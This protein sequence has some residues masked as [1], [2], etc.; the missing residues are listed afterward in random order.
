MKDSLKL[1]CKGFFGRCFMQW[2]FFL[3][4]TTPKSKAVTACSCNPF[5]NTRQHNSFLITCYVIK[6]LQKN[7]HSWVVLRLL[8]AEACSQVTLQNTW[9]LHIGILHKHSGVGDNFQISRKFPFPADLNEKAIP[10]LRCEFCIF[11]EIHRPGLFQV[12]L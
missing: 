3:L 8:E 5:Y 12:D 9:M 7:P 4:K 2:T 10:S 1:P 6:M 11:T